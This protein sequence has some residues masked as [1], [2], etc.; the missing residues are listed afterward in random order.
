MILNY[1][2]LWQW[3]VMLLLLLL[4]GPIHPPTANDEEPLGAVRIVLGW[5]TLAFILVGFTPV[6]LRTLS[7]ISDQQATVPSPCTAKRPSA[8]DVSRG[9]TS[10]S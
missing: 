1:Q 2:D 9:S 8:K 7:R 3:T 6:P 10:D 4:I 5:L